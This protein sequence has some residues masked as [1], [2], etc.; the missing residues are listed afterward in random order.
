[1]NLVNRK[2]T[3]RGNTGKIIIHD[4]REKKV[5]IE[6]DKSVF[7]Q[8]NVWSFDEDEVIKMLGENYKEPVCECGVNKLNKNNQT[9]YSHSTWCEMFVSRSFE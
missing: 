9:K 4:R 1:M 5:H 8:Y 3:I 7:G 6:F 2:V